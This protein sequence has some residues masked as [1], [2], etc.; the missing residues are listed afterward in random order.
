MRNLLRFIINNQFTLLFFIIEI[1]S[2]S[3]VIRSNKYPQARYINFAQNLN[4]F[5]SK[6]ISKFVQY[7]SLKEINAQLNAEND[8]L[9]NENER[10][11]LL[12]N[13][14]K[15]QKIASVDTINKI[16]FVYLVAKIVNNS[17][18]KQYNFITL[19]KGSFDGVK[20]ELAV[21]SPKGIIGKVVQV[22]D[23]YSLVMSVLNRNFKASAKIKKNN[24]FGSFE[25]DGIN[26][27]TATL[28]EIPLHVNIAT[29]D[30]II[31][32]GY[33]TIF[34]EGI[35]VGF[36]SNFSVHGGSFYKINIRLSN[37]FKNL[38]YVYVVMNQLKEEQKLLE[39]SIKHD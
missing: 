22:T 7:F 31:T 14:T 27:R 19:D 23:H 11:K 17:T 25:W 28:N 5:V 30:T 13:L 29:G 37:D 6:K 38:Y 9:K 18:D 35:L 24:Y 8:S 15:K 21:I 39:N 3:L 12:F 33:S 2:L 10:L 26:Y 4:G 34:P 36:I 16:R 1:I 20:T 32:T